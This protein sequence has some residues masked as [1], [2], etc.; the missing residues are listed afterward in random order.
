LRVRLAAA[1]TAAVAFVAGYFDRHER[2]R[3]AAIVAASWIG[4]ET[5][6]YVL[7]LA[8]FFD[9]GWA[10]C[11]PMAGIVTTVLLRS[12]RRRWRWIV[13]GFALGDLHAERFAPVGEMATIVVCNVA[14]VLIAAF[15]LPAF[16]NIEEWMQEPDLLAK[17][18]LWPVTLGPA[19]TALPVALYYSLAMHKNFWQYATRWGFGDT[20]GMVLW[21]PL[22]L[23]L[24]SR[25]TYDLFR[26]RVL[27]QTSALL[28]LTVA[29][30]LIVFDTKL[31]PP[32]FILMPIL[33]L[34]ALRLG[35]SGSA[36]AVNLLA[37]VA[38]AATLRG[39]GPFL[40]VAERFEDYRIFTL[41][42]F[43][44]LS[45]LMCLPVSVVLLEREGFAA[46]LKAALRRMQV[47]ATEDGLTGV[48][49]RRRFDETLEEEWRRAMREHEPL[50]L[51]M[52]DVDC[53][54]LY[55]DT[56]GH[57]GGDDCL[58]RV[59]QAILPIP[60]RAGDLVARYGGEEFAVLLPNTRAPG[61]PRWP[62]GCAARSRRWG[63]NTSGIRMAWSPSRW[64]AA[65][66]CLGPARRRRY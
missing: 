13:L 30:S 26:W 45:M 8:V 32:A 40:S 39:R 6:L 24:L 4:F 49:N 23:A 25:Q 34:V 58:R 22:M 1:G 50:A 16:R 42:V 47:L 48:A 28:G 60:N 7:G 27:P 41:Q 44:S 56:Y 3:T 66:W 62:T 15:A 29:A 37:V 54:K 17:F 9:N 20:L 61:R 53:F 10:V 43:L 36:L 55:N 46:G 51:L 11:W 5:I 57:L 65:R 19:M 63:C 31:A 21:L 2:L 18:I 52:I 12:E 59:A 33:L 38:T 35:F 14:E 64:D